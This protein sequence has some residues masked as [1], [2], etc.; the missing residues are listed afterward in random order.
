MKHTLAGN[1]GNGPARVLKRLFRLF[2][3]HGFNGGKRFFSDGFNLG[4]VGGVSNVPC[5]VLANSLDRRFMI[6]QLKFLSKKLKKQY[7]L[8]T[9]IKH[10]N[11]K[12]PD[13]EG[14]K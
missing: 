8:Q 3:I 5:V 4:A 1:F 14:K 9:G 11:R 13:L 10:D 12:I 7:L 2:F 6:C